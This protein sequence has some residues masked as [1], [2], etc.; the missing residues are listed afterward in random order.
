ML[1]MLNRNQIKNSLLCLGLSVAGLIVIL[2]QMTKVL[3][4][5]YLSFSSS[6]AIF[7][8]LDL[9]LSHNTGA[10]FSFLAQA[11]GWQRGFFIGLAAIVS[12]AIIIWLM[13]LRK[14]QKLEGIG[15]SLILGGALGNLWDRMMHGYVIDFILLYYKEWQWP[16]FN[17]ADTAICIGVACFIFAMF[18][19]PKN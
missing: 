6:L 16:V 5:R 9:T 13:Q 7:P 14:E 2:D 4:T 1:N 18:R 17:I 12:V 15:L 11:S 8:G 19:Q 10:A 3:S